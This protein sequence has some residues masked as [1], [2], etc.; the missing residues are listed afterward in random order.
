MLTYFFPLEK[1]LK[2]IIFLIFLTQSILVAQSN[3]QWL[4]IQDLEDKIVYLDVSSIQLLNKNLTL[5]SM[6]KYRKPV[7]LN[8][9]SK[10]VSSVKS[11]L[12]FNTTTETYSTIGILYYDHKGR[13][14]GET[15]GANII[16]NEIVAN[17]IKAN[18]TIKIIYAKAV[19][20]L[21]TGSITA[22]R[23]EFL[24]KRNVQPEKIDTIEA[25]TNQTVDIKNDFETLINQKPLETKKQNE[26]APANIVVTETNDT[27]KFIVGKQLK[28][29]LA[30]DVEKVRAKKDSIKKEQEKITELPVLT[31]NESL[32]EKSSQE[33]KKNTSVYDRTGD[34]NYRGNI[35]TDGNLYTIQVSSWR[36]KEKAENEVTRLKSAGHDAYLMEVFLSNKGQNW[37]RVRVGYFDSFDEAKNYENRIR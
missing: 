3:R 24:P 7:E 9:F 27:L 16:G 15:S 17:D 12:L 37:Y 36:N 26:E 19:E 30:D 4:I 14:I 10:K 8:P 18:E 22:E 21:N 34:R 13:I 31:V 6:I 23:S 29:V 32:P 20:Y 5:R 2:V 33:K 1:M 11:N 35:W 28:S 25:K